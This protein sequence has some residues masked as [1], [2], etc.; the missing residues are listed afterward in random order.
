MVQT[1]LLAVTGS[2]NEAKWG[3]I[4]K[5][6]NE[7]MK[8]SVLALAVHGA[9]LALCAMPLMSVAEDAAPAKAEDTANDE[10]ANLMQPN[11]FVELGVKGVSRDS[12]K[13]GEYSGL[14]DS[15]AYGIGNFDLR[16]GN[17]YGEGD[18]TIRWQAK[19][20]DLGT[21]ARSLGAS[22]E[23]QGQW[24]LGA[25]FDELRHKLSDSYQTPFIG[26]MGG[27]NF[28]LP[29]GFGLINTGANPGTRSLNAAQTGALHKVDIHTTRENT[30]ITAG[31]TISPEWDVKL[32]F[33][34]LYQTG[35]K[36]MAFG[37]A[38]IGS[39]TKATGEVVSILPNPTNYRTDSV[40]LALNW[41]GDKS[42]L[43]MAYYG[44]F[45]RDENSGVKFQTWAGVTSTQTMSTPP[46]NDFNQLS[47]LGGYTFSPKTKLV[48]SLSY[49]RGTQDDKFVVDPLMMITAPTRTSADAKV[50][51]THAD[52]RLTDQ[53]FN[54]LTLTAGVKYDERDNQTPSNIYNF[55]AISGSPGNIANYPNTP[56]S[57]RKTQYELAGDYRL[58]NKQHLRLSYNRDNIQRWCNNYAVGGGTPAYT[59]GTQCVVATSSKEDK[60]SATYRLNA[61]ENIHLNAGYSYAD[62]VTDFD[63]LARTAFIEVG[64]GGVG[65]TITGLN[66]GDFLGFHPFFDANRIQQGLKAGVDWQANDKLSINMNGRYTDDNYN[67]RYGFQNGDSWSFNLD[68]TFQVSETAS[69][70]AY[71]TKERRE[72]D[73]TNLQSITAIAST[74]SKLSV[75]AGGTWSNTLKDDDITFGVGAKKTGL[76]AGKFDLGADFTYS[77]GE[78][79]YSTLLNYNGVDNSG[80]TCSSAFYLTCGT[81]PDVKNKMTQFKLKGDY[82]VDKHSTIA[83]GYIYQ[84]LVSNDYYYN[85]LQYGFTPRNLM[86]DNQNSGSYSVNV[87]NATYT[88]NF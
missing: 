86:P 19:G 53:T 87:L 7:K 74:G 47:L 72:R 22:V 37:A 2:A 58:D 82:R 44:S 23:S 34:H 56:L 67:T 15:G 41:T 79:S 55:N 38:G 20:V 4:M 68:S 54:K 85:G 3:N 60:L 40:D 13:F 70:N 11:N 45:F 52:F 81:L 14:D 5:V 16:G 1:V 10:A 36:L 30:S 29:A 43:T 26:S 63:P 80:R 88:Y 31:Y 73:M 17:A 57:N 84:H 8:A 78:T 50:I 71:L 12:A 35:A 28:T 51:N 24:S 49:G 64:G 39:P 21:T 69:V 75:P 66:G 46:D 61:T 27:N 77:L 59:A 6:C 9:I 62:R 76:L 83:V 33:N 32:G 25:S 65:N 42:H 48:G 18:G